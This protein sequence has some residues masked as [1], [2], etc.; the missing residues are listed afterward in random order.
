MRIWKIRPKITAAVAAVFAVLLMGS[1]YSA[2]AATTNLL[3]G[4]KQYYTVMMRSDKQSLVY[5]KVTFENSSA[6]EDL[7]SFS[8][9]LPDDVAVSNLTVQQILAKETTRSCK[10]Y[11]TY[12]A[13]KSRVTYAYQYTQD[14][15]NQNKICLMYDETSAYD[16]DFDFDTNMSGTTEYYYYDY[17]LRR[18]ADNKFEYK[19]LTPKQTGQTYTVE[20][21]TPIHA[22]KQGAVLVAYTS[23]SYISGA[24][25]RFTYDFQTFTAKELVSKAVVAINFDDELYSRLTSSAR[26]VST[27]AVSSGAEGVGLDSST[28]YESKAVDEIQTGI[29]R[30]GRY[31]KEKAQLLPGETFSVQGVFATSMFMLYAP[32]ILWSLLTV[33]LLAA[34]GWFGYRFYRRKHPRVAKAAKT[35]AT[36]KNTS[37]AGEKTMLTSGITLK[38]ALLVSLAAIGAS[39][40]VVLLVIGLLALIGLHDS[41]NGFANSII[42]MAVCLALIV[43]FVIPFVYVLARYGAH[44]TFKWLVYHIVVL[45]TV[46]VVIC[47]VY[48]LVDSPSSSIMPCIYDGGNRS[49]IQ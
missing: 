7:T 21:P 45:L 6:T 24:L 8:F 35:G 25:G 29:G 2:H 27:A 43:L 31:V 30:G 26:Q 37:A 12:D 32:T 41:Y 33:A 42:L 20:L 10:T 38:S 4:Q 16:E 13:Y 40:A 1:P 3:A 19:D 49:V 36:D 23:K 5:A 11:E 39:V 46:L 9:T 18:S 28:S 17:Y 47:C 48:A 44:S 14:Y 34:G 22:K 15:Y